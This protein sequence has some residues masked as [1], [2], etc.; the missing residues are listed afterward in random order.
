MTDTNIDPIVDPYVPTVGDIQAAHRLFAYLR[1]K[2]FEMD[3][4]VPPVVVE[5]GS[6]MLDLC[7]EELLKVYPD[8]EEKQVQVNDLICMSLGAISFQYLL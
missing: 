8:D 2:H 6:K 5:I 4:D 7:D 1:N 3:N